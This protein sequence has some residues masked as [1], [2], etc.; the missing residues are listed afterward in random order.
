[1]LDCL[2]IGDSIALGTH[3]QYKQCGV[4]AKSGID[5]RA[6]Y[7]RYH[8]YY[9]N[10]KTEHV[11]ISI[12]SNDK[13]S[14]MSRYNIEHIRNTIGD[15]KKVFWIL[16]ANKENIAEIIRNIAR[17]K[18]DTVIPIRY[19]SKDGVHPTIDGYKN[20]VRQ[21]RYAG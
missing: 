21:I 7:D 9:A 13:Y 11:I 8:R 3:S 5:S 20:I 14:N 15:N 18:K 2:I 6:F 10:T 1:M 4:I 12:G 16:P 19:L 17:D